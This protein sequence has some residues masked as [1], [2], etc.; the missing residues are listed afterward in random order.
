MNEYVSSTDLIV[1]ENKSIVDEKVAVGPDAV[2]DGQLFPLREGTVRV[3]HGR[4]CA[5]VV[6][7]GYL[8]LNHCIGEN[9]LHF[10]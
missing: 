7:S 8:S 2:E 3:A 1:G 5:R 10:S 9:N 4:A 6:V